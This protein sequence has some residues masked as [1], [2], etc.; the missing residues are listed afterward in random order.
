MKLTYSIPGK[1]SPK[2][3]DK[4]NRSTFQV[5][6]VLPLSPYQEGLL[7]DFSFMYFYQL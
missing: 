5:L 2:I 6:N 1:I 7:P 3:Y 4:V